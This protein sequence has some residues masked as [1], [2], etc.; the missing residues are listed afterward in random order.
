MRSRSTWRAGARHS[1]RARQQVP[2]G[3]L[4]YPCNV[5]GCSMRYE[6]LWNYEEQLSAV[7]HLGKDYSV[8]ATFMYVASL[9][10]ALRRSAR[11][12]SP[13]LGRILGDPA[14]PGIALLT[15]R[16][17]V[18][19]IY[20]VNGYSGTSG[21]CLVYPHHAEACAACDIGP[22]SAGQRKLTDCPPSYVLS[23]HLTAAGLHG[24]ARP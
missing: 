21:L 4:I 24:K 14:A 9:L 11:C 22:P 3:H 13:A 23:Y 6:H 18:S 16:Q 15:P 1:R 20:A 12:D 5:C 17:A 10:A 7:H 2:A 19:Q 8:S